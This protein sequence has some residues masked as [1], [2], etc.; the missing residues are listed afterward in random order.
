MKSAVKEL[1]NAILTDLNF[2]SSKD[3]NELTDD[4]K[5]RLQFFKDLLGLGE[6]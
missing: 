6:G 1:V 2:L 3:E 5:Q 4:A